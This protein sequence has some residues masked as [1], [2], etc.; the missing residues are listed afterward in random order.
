MRTL[1]RDELKVVKQQLIMLPFGLVTQHFVCNDVL[2][3]RTLILLL[4]SKFKECIFGHVI[5]TF[6]SEGYQFAMMPPLPPEAMMKQSQ[7][8]T[9]RNRV[10]GA[11][12]KLEELIHAQTVQFML[13]ASNHS[14]RYNNM[15]AKEQE[16]TP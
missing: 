11:S 10:N 6:Q 4:F 3:Y 15:G 16:N 1:R 14:S 5:A 13:G 12:Q 2:C 9:T 7:F 8:S